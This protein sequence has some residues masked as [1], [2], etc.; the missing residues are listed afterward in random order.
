MSGANTR[1]SVVGYSNIQ[2]HYLILD[3][4]PYDDQFLEKEL[5]K[6]R[7]MTTPLTT[8]RVIDKDNYDWSGIEEKLPVKLRPW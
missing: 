6:G 3:W 8:W 1:F 7:R 4:L 2:G 5:R